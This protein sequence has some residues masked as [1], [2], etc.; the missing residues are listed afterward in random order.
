MQLTILTYGSIVGL[1]IITTNCLSLEIGLG[2]AWL[3]FLVMFIAFGTIFVAIRQY[4]DDTLG[5]VMRFSSGF[6]LGL[7]I[8][9]VASVV[10]VVIWELYLFVTDYHFIDD[11]SN[12]LITS[13]QEA[14]ASAAELDAARQNAAEFR[15]QYA[16]PL[17]RLPLTFLEIFPV[18]ALIAVV[19]AIS[20]RSQGKRSS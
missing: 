11:Y 19:S 1:V 17:V 13:N 7:C 12:S 4:R 15:A 6:L 18:G 3:G 5:G 2:Q 9:A 8:S 20:L 16:N 14:A 10:Y